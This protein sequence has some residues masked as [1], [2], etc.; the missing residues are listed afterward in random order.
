MLGNYGSKGWELPEDEEGDGDGGGGKFS[1]EERLFRFR[2]KMKDAA[3]NP[4]KVGTPVTHRV[5]FLNGTPYSYYEHG[6]WKFKGCGH[7]SIMCLGRNKNDD[8]GCPLCDKNFGDDWPA[9]IGLFGIIDMGQVEYLPGGQIKLHHR[10]WTNKDNEEIEDAFPRVLLG[11]KKG[12]KKSPGVLKK[13]AWY[14]DRH[15]GTL[16]GT[17]WDTSRSGDKEAGVGEDW[18]YV[19]RVA[20]EDY[21][22]YLQDLGADPDKL[23]V[24]PITNWNEIC[25]PLSYEAVCRIAGKPLP[26]GAKQGG[27]QTDGAGYEGG[28]G[29]DGPQDDDIPF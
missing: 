28:G 22:K 6:T 3:N 18:N 13:L 11:A 20:P 12:S 27:S 1:E 4:L 29:Y 21:A 15:G 14:A 16:E 2:F 8:R 9:F 5:L 19:E 10:T 25:K 7:Y 26:G 23:N 17:V 24:D